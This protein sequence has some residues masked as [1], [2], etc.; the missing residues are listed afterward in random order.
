[1]VM[2]RMH[3]GDRVLTEAEWALFRVGLEMLWDDIEAGQSETGIRVFDDLQP[4]QKL[5]LLSDVGQA[6]RDPAILT[7]QPLDRGSGFGCT[8]VGL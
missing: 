5:A 7:P 1:M 6:L 8:G 3:D 4:E 2:W